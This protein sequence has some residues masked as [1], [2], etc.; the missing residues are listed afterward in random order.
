MDVIKGNPTLFMRRDEVEAAWTWV[1]PI[2][3]RWATSA[4]PAEALPGRHQRARPPPQPCSSATAE[5][6]RSPNQ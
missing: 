5:P 1:E 4:R 3:T 2:L 6:G